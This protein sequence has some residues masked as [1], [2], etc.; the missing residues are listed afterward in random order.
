MPTRTFAL[1]AEVETSISMCAIKA[2]PV[3]AG[4]RA[5]ELLTAVVNSR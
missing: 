4:Y 1:S 5:K 2:K 3:S